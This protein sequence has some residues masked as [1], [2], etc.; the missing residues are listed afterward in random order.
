MVLTPEAVLLN[1]LK[2]HA[3]A[4]KQF[5][6]TAPDDVAVHRELLRIGQSQM[7]FYYGTLPVETIASEAIQALGRLQISSSEA[8]VQ[9]LRPDGFREFTA[10]DGTSWIFREG[11]GEQVVHLH[12]GRYAAHTIRIKASTLKTAALV[13][14]HIRLHQLLWPASRDVINTLRMT[15]L[16]LPPIGSAEGMKQ[17]ERCVNLLLQ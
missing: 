5:L 16:N 6:E 12:P 11:Q 3:G 14:R 4:L 2:H 17:V 15:G 13:Y 10:G 1:P 8:F 9:W 7:D